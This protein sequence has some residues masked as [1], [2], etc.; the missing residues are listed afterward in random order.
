MNY[1]LN[2]LS[3]SLLSVFTE[4]LHSYGLVRLPFHVFYSR[5]PETDIPCSVIEPN[6]KSCR[7]YNGGRIA[8]KQVAAILVSAS[9]AQC[10]FARQLSDFV[11]SSAIHLHSSLKVIPD[12][13]FPPPFLYPFTTAALQLLQRRAV[14]QSRLYG[15]ADT[16]QWLALPLLYHLYYSVLKNFVIP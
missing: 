8:G 5:Y 4:Y 10:D 12:G 15:V 11:T 14:W 7:L 16:S 9:F 2:N 3:P 1:A 13:F 6:F